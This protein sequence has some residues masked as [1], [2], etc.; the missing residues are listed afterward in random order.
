M[1]TR[2]GV[3]V[4]PATRD[5][6]ERRLGGEAALAVEF[7]VRLFPGRHRAG[8]AELIA[9]T[10]VDDM[11]ALGDEAVLERLQVATELADPKPGLT[12]SGLRRNLHG[13]GLAVDGEFFNRGGRGN[14]AKGHSEQSEEDAGHDQSVSAKVQTCK[15]ANVAT[16]PDALTFAP[17]HRGLGPDLHLCT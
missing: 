8:G 1:Q 4:K 9:H 10:D 13:H 12:G 16:E 3:H 14:G 15:G 2:P 7:F 6:E 5:A 17:L 11:P